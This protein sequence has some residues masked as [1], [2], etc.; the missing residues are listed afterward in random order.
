MCFLLEGTWP[1][2]LNSFRSRKLQ[3]LKAAGT[4]EFILEQQSDLRQHLSVSTTTP[5]SLLWASVKHVV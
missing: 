1:Q 4:C 3:G 2:V 5:F